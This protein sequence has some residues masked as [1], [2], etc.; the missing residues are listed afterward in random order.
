MVAIFRIARKPLND[1]LQRIGPI[2]A[3]LG[4]DYAREIRGRISLIR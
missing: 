2:V 1:S 3:A 4:R